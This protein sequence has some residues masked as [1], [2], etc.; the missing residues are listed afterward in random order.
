M[1]SSPDGGGVEELQK[2]IRQHVNFQNHFVVG[3]SVNKF[4]AGWHFANWQV[5]IEVLD[6]EN[7][8]SGLDSRLG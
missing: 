2:P 1:S 4:N 8:S 6:P 3:R 5:A 7:L